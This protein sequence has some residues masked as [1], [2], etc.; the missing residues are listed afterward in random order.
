MIISSFNIYND[1]RKHEKNKA[2]EILDYIKKYDIDIIGLQEVYPSLYNELNKSLENRKYTGKFR[3]QFP[4]NI[5][6]R[7]LNEANPIITKYEVLNKEYYSMPFLPSTRMR[8]MTKAIIKYKNELVSIYCTHLE[9]KYMN[10]K[11]KQL[12]YIYNLIEKDPNKIILLGDFNLKNN[13]RSI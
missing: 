9:Y 2:K 4:G 3:Y 8:M 7:F 6:L 5:L 10:V 1:F 12:N 13:K 11:I